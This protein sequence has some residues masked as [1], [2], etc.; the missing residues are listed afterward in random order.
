MSLLRSI[1]GPARACLV[2]VFLAALSWTGPAWSGQSQT[3]SIPG[4]QPPSVKAP[5]APRVKPPQPPQ[6]AAPAGAQARPTPI[7]PEPIFLDPGFLDQ[8]A[9]EQTGVDFSLLAKAYPSL[10]TIVL[11]SFD[12]PLDFERLLRLRGQEIHP[13]NGTEVDYLGR[14]YGIFHTRAGNLPRLAGAPGV[15]A[16]IPLARFLLQG[17]YRIH[18]KIVEPGFT[19]RLGFSVSSPRNSFGKTLLQAEN[20]IYPRKPF[21]IREDEAGNLWLETALEEAKEGDQLKID[22]SCLYLVDMAGL[23][24]HAILTT[25]VRPSPE[26]DPGDPAATF[27]EPGLKIKPD[28][29][30]VRA[31]AGEI[32]GEERIPR[33]VWARISKFIKDNIPYDH[34]KRAE[35]FGGRKVYRSMAEM[36]DP[37]EVILE[38][39]VGACPETCLLEASLFRAV[40]IP[41]RTAGRWGHFFT[42]VYLPGRGWV[43]TS[44]TPTGIPLV[45]DVNAEHTPFVSWDREV[46]VRTTRWTGDVRIKVRGLP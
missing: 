28:L 19:G 4:P 35:F 14:T 40:G 11:I 33:R 45:R 27:L 2:L 32:L 13:V 34:Q 22:F 36:Y 7:L 41:A 18:F 5:Q 23:L 12:W 26:L 30:Q 44:V 25:P 1:S 31:L 20:H 17:L 6:G 15:R 10:K 24:N 21:S 16:A 42:E 39:R 46:A 43:S 37:P 9:R 29:E 3:L 8:V 38:R